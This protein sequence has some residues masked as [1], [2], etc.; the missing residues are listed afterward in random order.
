VA[1]SLPDPEMIPT[2]DLF[3]DPINPRLTDSDFS[4]ND[5]DRI[6]K[7]L[8]TE[9]NVSEIVDSIVASNG[10]WKHEPLV[11][12]RENGKLVVIEGN[13]RLASVKLL[14]S[15]EK[16]RLVGATGIP[17]INA[18][19]ETDLQQLP[20][21]ERTRQQVW[22]FIGYKHVRGPQEWDSIAKAEYIARI[23]EEYGI[24]LDD[25]AR[26][27]GDRNATARRLYHGLKVLHQAE[28]AG[29]FD[30]KDRFYQR[31]DFAYSHLWTGLGYE[32][33]RDFLGLKNGDRDER[34]PIARKNIP[35]L[36]ELCLWLYGSHSNNIEPLVKTQNP[37]LR[38]LDEAL[39]APRGIAAL[40]R[41]LPLQFAVN[42]AR[43][44]TRLLLDALVSAEQNLR[45]AKGYFSTGYKGQQEIADT[46][47]NIHSI[48]D[49]LQ[50]ELT[51]AGHKK[52]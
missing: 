42:A 4:I 48:A 47:S 16:Q 5:Q 35:A 12:A 22:D 23:H 19:L 38:Q 29:V 31:K 45:E 30:P 2:R 51:A 28:D 14:L 34:K 15:S 24:E 7:R 8:W 33:I 25:I 41:G 1:E 6:L 36:G 50:K 43:G 18:Q 13:R 32:G 49:S 27:I 17:E 10:F 26:A 11:A 20:V 52:K 40:R 3:L 21:I 39:R 46:I 37:H 9:F 44:D